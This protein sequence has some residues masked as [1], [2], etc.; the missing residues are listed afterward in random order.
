MRAWVFTERGDPAQVLTFMT[1]DK[2]TLPPRAPLPRDAPT[3]EEWV[4]IKTAFAGLN[5]GAIFQMTLIPPMLRTKT[6]VPEMDLSGVV[7]DVWHP[8]GPAVP[9]PEFRFRKG[10]KV[11]AMLPAGHA[12]A[13]GTGALAEYVAIPA[14]YVARKPDGVSFGDAA[15]CLL[16]GMTAWQ[17][18][19]ESGA[20]AGDRVLVNAASGGIGTMVVQMVRNV[21]GDSGH[22]VGICSGKNVEMV[23]SL[24]ADEV[25][26]PGVTTFFFSN[27]F[28]LVY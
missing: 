19:Q 25:S 23:K 9:A 7:E 24:G 11:V 22:V 10:D 18:V 4:L 20:K 14:K 2:P 13:T 28:Y 16:A 5:V 6:C 3:P 12:L 27:Y 15:G 26:F 21:V 1:L 8:D 17:Q